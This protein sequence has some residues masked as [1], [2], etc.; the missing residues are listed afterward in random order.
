YM[1]AGASA[2][3]IGS[4]VYYRGVDVFRKICK[5]IKTWMK[6]NDY[7]KIDEIVGVGLK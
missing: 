3:Q 6:K 7:K 1:M 2:V 4:G 5:E